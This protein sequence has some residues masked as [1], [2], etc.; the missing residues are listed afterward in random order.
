M[1]VSETA[2]AGRPAVIS[3]LTVSRTANFRYNLIQARPGV[4]GMVQGL[5]IK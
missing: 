3:K 2:V 1:T 5:S 4:D